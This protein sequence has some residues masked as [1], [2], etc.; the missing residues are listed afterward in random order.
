MS[1]ESD[2]DAI[3]SRTQQLLV[4]ITAGDWDAYAEI[5]DPTLTCFEPEALGNLVDGLD[6]HRYYFN[7]PSSGAPTAVQSTMIGPH[8]RIIG[9]VGIIAYVRL[10]QKMVDGKPVTTAMEETRVWH[11]QNGKWKHVHFHRSPA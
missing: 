8:I 10:T 4:A 9:D 1:L 2:R 7:L 6:F 11:R 3:L 5:C